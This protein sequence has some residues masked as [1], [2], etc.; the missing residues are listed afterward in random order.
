MITGANL[1]GKVDSYRK[2][3][4]RILRILLVGILFSFVYYLRYVYVSQ[5]SV[6]FV[7]F[8]KLIYHN[9]ITNAYWYLYMYLGILIMMP[10]LQRMSVYMKKMIICIYCSGM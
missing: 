6:H 3:T 4:K 8:L 5:E 2:H 10:L 9:N 7:E 1:L